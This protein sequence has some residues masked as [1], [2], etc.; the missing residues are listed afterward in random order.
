VNSS[1]QAKVIEAGPCLCLFKG[2]DLRACMFQLSQN[3][4]PEVLLKRFSRLH[5]Y[6]ERVAGEVRLEMVKR[7][8]VQLRAYI[9]LL[10]C[11]LCLETLSFGIN[12]SATTSTYFDSC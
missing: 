5:T 8:R 10:L 1:Y 4:R 6:R 3:R 11:G 2:H 9:D 7:R 12:I